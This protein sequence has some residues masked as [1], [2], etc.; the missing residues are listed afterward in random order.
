MN[1]NELNKY[2]YHYLTKDMTRSAIMLDGEWGIG[3]SYYIQKDLIPYL[4]NELNK[5]ETDAPQNDRQPFQCVVVS[6]YG[7]S[8]LAELGK[9]LYFQLRTKP[10]QMAIN[11]VQSKFHLHS[12][13]PQGGKKHRK[14]IK[15]LGKTIG[16]NTIKSI[17]SFFNAKDFSA[18]EQVHEKEQSPAC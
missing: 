15:A 17:A 13:K 4:A 3:K 10:V 5:N 14:E 6:L 8:S 16:K 7:I 11:N 2:I 1:N 12:L 9:I 18:L